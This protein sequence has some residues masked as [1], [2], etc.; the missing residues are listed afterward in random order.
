MPRKFL[1]F[2]V[3]ILYLCV[4]PLPAGAQVSA[5]P[6]PPASAPSG[7]T[8]EGPHPVP[9]HTG[10]ATLVKDTASDF[11]AYP[12]RKSTW[13]ILGMGAAAALAVHPADDYVEEHIVGNETATDIFKL[14]KW[15]GSSYV[16]VGSAIGLWVVGRYILPSGRESRTNKVSHLGFDLLR[17]QIV[18]QAL[19]QGM[20]YSFQRNRP[21]GECCAFPSGHAAAAFASAA[22]L[23]RHMGYRASWPALVGATYVAASRLVD[24]RHFLSDVVF[25]AAVGTTAGWTVVGRHGRNEYAL[26]PTPVRGGMM[27]SLARVAN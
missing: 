2:V 19:V 12:K 5:T 7:Q 4:L 9:A 10:W 15:V 23:E 6:D 20:K 26:I 27:I 11:V 21:T 13:V 22:V 25:G 18:S 17:A 8:P 16:Q 14:G 1:I 24:N 3:I